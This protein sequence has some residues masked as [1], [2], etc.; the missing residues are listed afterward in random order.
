M[1]RARAAGSKDEPISDC[2]VR[3][4]NMACTC[5]ASLRVLSFLF[6][7]LSDLHTAL[8]GALLEVRKAGILYNT[9]AFLTSNNAFREAFG[10]EKSWDPLQHG[11]K[12]GGK[13]WAVE[14]R[15]KQG[16]KSWE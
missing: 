12:G 7:S 11:G 1:I 14:G 5:M 2:A 6:I 10:S 8:S 9:L 3:A 13:Q 15:K 16:E 4:A